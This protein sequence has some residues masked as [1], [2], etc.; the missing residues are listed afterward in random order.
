MTDRYDYDYDYDGGMAYNG[1]GRR[2]FDGSEGIKG[3]FYDNR[4]G[5]TANMFNYENDNNNND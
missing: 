1:G 5:T 4:G 2:V 3:D